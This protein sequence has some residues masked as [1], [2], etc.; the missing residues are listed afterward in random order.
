MKYL[1]LEVILLSVFIS[2]MSVNEHKRLME[3]KDLTIQ[4]QR[5]WNEALKKENQQLKQKN[6]ELEEEIKPYKGLSAAEAKLKQLALEKAAM[7][8]EEQLRKAE[9]DKANAEELEEKK[10][11]EELAKEEADADAKYA[12]LGVR[13]LSVTCSWQFVNND[14]NDLYMPKLNIVLKNVSGSAIT[15]GIVKVIF[16]D[17]KNKL[18]YSE[19]HDYLVYKYLGQNPLENGY[20][21]EV[22]IV[23]S[24]GYRSQYIETP[25]LEAEIYYEGELLMTVKVD[26]N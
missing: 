5:N 8:Q 17:K 21:K 26:R 24:K 20:S 25:E 13:P 9:E 16:V 11:A 18:I 19:N 3:G 14:G 23:A 4:G 7:D 22:I 6:D 10:Q 15:E 12:E 1:I 2:C